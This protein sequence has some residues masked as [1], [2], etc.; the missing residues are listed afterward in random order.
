MK[1]GVV[2]AAFGLAVCGAWA[3]G[4]AAEKQDVL[5]E[6]FGRLPHVLLVNVNGAVDNQAL[7]DMAGYAYATLNTRVWTNAADEVSLQELCATAAPCAKWGTNTVAV[8]YVEKRAGLPPALMAPGAKW[9]IVNVKGLDS[10]KPADAQLRRRLRQVA[11]RGV[12]F[13]AGAGCAATPRCVTDAR[14]V[15]LADFDRGADR[16][17]GETAARVGELLGPQARAFL[18]PGQKATKRKAAPAAK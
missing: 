6:A 14:M 7:A 13:A 9:A 3:E 12:A 4:S 16:Y 8:V 5:R 10:D 1:V 18:F 17:D 15:S 11:L 2:L